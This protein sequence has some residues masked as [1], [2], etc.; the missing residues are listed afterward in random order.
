MKLM[1]NILII[2]ILSVFAGIVSAEDV[3]QPSPAVAEM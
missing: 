2:A 1:L 3:A